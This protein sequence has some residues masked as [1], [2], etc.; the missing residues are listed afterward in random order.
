V[1][2]YPI[3]KLNVVNDKSAPPLSKGRLGGVQI[4]A[5]QLDD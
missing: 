1:E 5:T 3:F 4:S 2:I